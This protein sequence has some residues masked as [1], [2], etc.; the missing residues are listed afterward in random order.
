MW[1]F[2]WWISVRGFYNVENNKWYFYAGKTAG[3]SVA[4]F[5]IA[6]ARKER[7]FKWHH[8]SKAN[9]LL[10][11]PVEFRNTHNNRDVKNDHRIE[12]EIL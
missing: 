5:L 2:I 3:K 6:T 1:K 10:R 8:N 7:N 9:K 4:I 12:A 11:L